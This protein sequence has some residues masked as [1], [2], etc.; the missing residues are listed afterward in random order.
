MLARG[1]RTSACVEVGYGTGGLSMIGTKMSYMD[2]TAFA[3]VGGIQELSFDEVDNVNGGFIPII[4]AY[5]AIAIAATALAAGVA[6]VA[7]AEL[8]YA[9]NRD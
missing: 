3:D 9:A 6:F 4:V 1:G 2:H 5:Y 7:S 8:G